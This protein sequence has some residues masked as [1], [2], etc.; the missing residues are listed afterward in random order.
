VAE[1]GLS[2]GLAAVRA[3][4]GRFDEARALVARA[5]ATMA[6]RG[7]RQAGSGIGFISG[8][9]EL[10]AGD[11]EAAERE[12]RDSLESLS[13][14]G[15]ESRGAT[16]ALMLGRVLAMQERHDEAEDV[17]RPWADAH[18][19]EDWSF[20][21]PA[22]KATILARRGELDEAER[23]AR[24]AATRSEQTDF[25]NWHGDVLLDLAEVLRAA[26]KPEE[27]RTAVEQALALYE[28]KGNVVSANA[29][30]RLLA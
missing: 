11:H 14:L 13:G 19:W 24:D 8:S 22:M 5:K 1:A 12:L 10:L 6:E 18:S 4:Q 21:H 27:A 29:A 28:Q 20:V 2:R 3:Q 15:L 7:L 25:L 17:M 23:L 30:R 26:G 16:L 9:V